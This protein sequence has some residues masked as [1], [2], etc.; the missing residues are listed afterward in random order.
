MIVA[1]ATVTMIL[2]FHSNHWSGWPGENP[3]ILHIADAVFRAVTSLL[4]LAGGGGGAPV[5]FSNRQ[6][7][8][9]YNGKS[10]QKYDYNVPTKQKTRGGGMVLR[11]NL[12]FFCN[13]SYDD[14]REH[15]TIPQL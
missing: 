1:R 15:I 6:F 7:E 3:T 4:K 13:I 14:E 9:E 11:E 8:F 10:S 2:N 5:K 12:K